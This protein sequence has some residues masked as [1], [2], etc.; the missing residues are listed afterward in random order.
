M[1]PSIALPSD[2]KLEVFYRVEPGCLGPQGKNQIEAFCQ[3]AQTAVTNLDADYVHWNII[4]RYDKSLP[5]MEYKVLSKRLSHQ[6][7]QRYLDVFRQELDQFEEHLHERLTD[8]IE[9]F[10]QRR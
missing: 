1:E 4:P 5:E 6:Q 9:D 3:F 7:A 8:L 10:L 2:K